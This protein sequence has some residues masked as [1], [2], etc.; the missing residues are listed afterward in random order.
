MPLVQ[1]D[2]VTVTVLPAGSTEFDPGADRLSE[3]PFQSQH[4]QL[5]NMSA[6]DCARG[7]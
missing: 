1:S 7:K 4:N 2:V 3:V 5:S 6:M